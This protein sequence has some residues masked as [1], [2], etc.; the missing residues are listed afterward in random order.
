MN[1]EQVYESLTM[2]DD[3]KKDW[4]MESAT[5]FHDID[6]KQSQELMSNT[7]CEIK[8]CYANSA[9]NAS[10]NLAYHGRICVVAQYTD[11]D[12]ACVLNTG[13]ESRGSNDGYQR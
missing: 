13:W 3:F 12:R 11:L 7:N 1:R 4:F 2:R 10:D 8:Q 6:R 9:R 5:V